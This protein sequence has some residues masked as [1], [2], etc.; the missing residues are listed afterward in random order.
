MLGPDPYPRMVRDFHRVIGEEA[1]RQIRKR[2]GKHAPDLVV[3]CVG[4]GSN[5]IGIFTAFLDDERVRLIGV[6]GGGRGEALGEHAARFD[7]GSLGVLHGTRTF[8]L[9]DQEGQIATTHSV[10]AGLDYP[11]IG[12]EHVALHDAGRV[13]YTRASDAEAVAGL[14]SAGR[15]PK[16]SCRRSRAPTPW[17]RSARRAPKLTPR[18]VIL[19]NLSGRGDKDVESVLAYD[20]AA[21]ARTEAEEE[22]AGRRRLFSVHGA[23]IERAAPQE[24]PH[25]AH[26]VRD[27]EGDDE[28]DATEA[29][30]DIPSGPA[31]STGEADDAGSG[32]AG[33]EAAEDDEGGSR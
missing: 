26:R 9:Q 30:P 21:R 33:S 18:H 24:R 2:E 5:S 12:P 23:G 3:A 4:G 32:A 6:E 15:A 16:A 29:P 27:G 14:P 25:G 17:P 8:V 31:E 20:E 1:K 11:A 13:E 22:A 19:V 7:G 10:S 28:A